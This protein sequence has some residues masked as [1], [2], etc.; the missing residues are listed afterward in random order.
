MGMGHARLRRVRSRTVLFR[1]PPLRPMANVR[2]GYREERS[3][4]QKSGDVYVFSGRK[5]SLPY[6]RFRG[7]RNER[8]MEFGRGQSHDHRRAKKF[9]SLCLPGGPRPYAAASGLPPGI[10]PARGYRHPEK[11]VSRRRCGARDFA[12]RFSG[13]QS[14]FRFGPF[15]LFAPIPAQIKPGKHFGSGETYLKIIRMAEAQ[16]SVA[17]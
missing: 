9:R 2:G 10:F 5:L 8:H 1:G 13:S 15:Q 4:S 16:F 14:P 6:Y 7:G 17:Q 12:A 11:G 3:G